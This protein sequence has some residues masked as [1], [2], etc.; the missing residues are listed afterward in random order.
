MSDSKSG[1]KTDL[2]ESNMPLL[3]DVEKS[4]ETP[5]KEQIEMKEEQE[6]KKDDSSEKGKKKK[7]KKPKE[8]KEK[9]PN[10]IDLISKDLDLGNRDSNNVNVEIDLDFD[11]VLAE[12]KA[13]QGFEW[14]W[15]LAFVVFSQIR[16]WIYKIFA[17]VV[18]LP[19]A[20][21]WAM[22]FALITVIHVWIL[23]PAN[24]L[25]DLILA[26]I[27]KIVVGVL[28]VTVAPLSVAV[29]SGCSKIKLTQE[30]WFE[31]NEENENLMNMKHLT[32]FSII[33]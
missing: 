16:I 15:R 1:S 26:L 27:R 28:G 24:R 20:I 25:F 23:S 5:E 22:V 7:E 19:C 32:D 33:H 3:D 30:V 9:G 18:A 4:G 11:D 17:A 10:C 31:L 13:A 12:P 2:N 21:L 6:E 14:V 29:F 8:K